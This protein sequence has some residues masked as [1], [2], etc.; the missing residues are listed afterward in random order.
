MIARCPQG[1]LIGWI[2]YIRYINPIAFPTEITIKSRD[3]YWEKLDKDFVCIQNRHFLS[4]K[5][6]SVK[7]MDNIT[8]QE[9]I[10]LNDALRSDLD[11]DRRTLAGDTALQCK[12]L[13]AH[14]TLKVCFASY[15]VHLYWLL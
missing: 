11:T 2:L 12:R 10:Y 3:K 9:A 4:A 8:I 1:T 14:Q 6:Q 13:S 15:C 7:Y 5:M